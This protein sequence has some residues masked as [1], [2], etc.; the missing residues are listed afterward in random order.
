[1]KL[2]LF[3]ALPLFE[4]AA[5]QLPEPSV[6][7]LKAMAS[8]VSVAD[9]DQD[10]FKDLSFLSVDGPTVNLEIFWGD[11]RKKFEKSTVHP[12]GS[13]NQFYPGVRDT[14]S[15]VTAVADWN[16]D[17]LLDV[18]V[19]GGILLNRGNRKFQWMKIPGPTEN[20]A[21]IAFVDFFG[22][23]KIELL[24]GRIDGT[25]ERCDQSQKCIGF[26]PAGA[27]FQQAKDF[28]VGDFDGDGKPDVV[29]GFRYDD[30][31]NSYAWFSMNG[32]S[33]PTTIG[34]M[35]GVDF[36]VGDIDEDGLP[37]IVAQMTET[38][39]DFPSY[40]EVWKNKGGRFEKI[41]KLYNHD[42]HN[43]A[44]ALADF[45][46]DGRLDYLQIGVDIPSIGLRRGD[47][48]F[49]GPHNS[50]RQEDVGWERLPSASGIGVQCLEI[51]DVGPCD[52]VIRG[53]ATPARS[54][55]LLVYFR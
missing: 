2:L 22:N 6:I 13:N 12:V 55:N 11:K 35:H 36:E 16:S 48:R 53:R 41:Q 25:I 20:L 1:M 29:S 50:S 37:D 10:G 8:A 7:P 30:P 14:S 51:D 40:T 17:R 33:M 42:N 39:A 19:A 45:D 44:S 23:G 32:W 47:G 15:Q 21:P 4:V 52:L 27:A 28:V 5:S 49:L 31:Y 46:G 18:G 26:S 9:L 34:G 38:I 24:R 43:E 3:F 54:P